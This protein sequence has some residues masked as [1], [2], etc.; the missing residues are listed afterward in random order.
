MSCDAEKD[1]DELGELNTFSLCFEA[2]QN[3]DYHVRAQALKN[4]RTHFVSEA[5]N[6]VKEFLEESLSDD[7]EVVVTETVYLLGAIAV[8][9]QKSIK[10]NSEILSLPQDD[11]EAVAQMEGQ[12]QQE[13]EE[14]ETIV[15]ELA[16]ILRDCEGDKTD[17]Y[18]EVRM[19]SAICL[20]NLGKD[21]SSA[22]WALTS[23]YHDNYEFQSVGDE[24]EKAMKKIKDALEKDN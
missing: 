3:G 10:H 13:R 7:S 20:G 8:E 19:A 4:M 21:A 11:I 5:R 12:R 14:V 9:H 18:E 6:H 1:A 17:R 16:N 24:A 22:L 23:A 15:D 2:L